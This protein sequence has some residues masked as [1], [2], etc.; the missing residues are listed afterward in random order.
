M[1]QPTTD[2]QP[3]YPQV[4][5][6]LSGE[7]GNGLAIVSRV[8]A[9]LRRAGVPQAKRDEFAEDATSADYDHL[10]QTVQRWVE[11]S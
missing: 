2:S 3:F 8:S 9:A 1:T 4:H 6:A 10:L 5:I 7:D 11:V